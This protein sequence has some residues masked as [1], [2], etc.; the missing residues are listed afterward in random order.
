MSQTTHA[1]TTSAITNVST[2]AKLVSFLKYI[3]HASGKRPG[4][5]MQAETHAHMYIGRSSMVPFAIANF[6][7]TGC[8][9][10]GSPGS[11][12]VCVT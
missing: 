3:S 9:F 12:S 2:T 8:S 4:D 11:R 5:A 7:D 1:Q 6:S 10:L